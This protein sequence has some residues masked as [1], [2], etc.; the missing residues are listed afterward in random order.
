MSAKS[1]P[2]IIYDL[3]IIGGGINGVGI[4]ADAAGRGLSV[5]LCEQHDLGSATSWT[6]SKLIHGGLRY[7]EHYEFKLVKEALS[8]RE[9]LLNKAPHLI[10]PQ[11]FILPHSR[12]L[13]P[14]WMI[15]AG[16]FLYDHLAKRSLLPASRSVNL[17][18]TLSDATLQ[19]QFNK[20]FIYSDC[21]VDDS[22]LVIT[23]ALAA[24]QNGA[25]ILPRWH[26]N[27]AFQL[28][29]KN[30]WQIELTKVGGPGKRIILAKALVN[31]TGPWAQSFIENK[32]AK[33]SPRI[34]R[35]VKGSHI[36][37][38]NSSNLKYAFI[39]QNED[40]RVVF[41]IPY[42]QHYLLVG[43]TDV[44]HLGSLEEVKASPEEIEYLLAVYNQYFTQPIFGS[45]IISSFAGVRPL[46]DDESDEASAVTRDY[47][48]EI[49]R[50][51]PS[52]LSIFGG[53]LTTYRRLAESALSLLKNDFPTM[54]PEWTKH[55]PL[56]GGDFRFS[57]LDQLQNQ[58]QLKRPWMDNALCSRLIHGYGTQALDIFSNC[59]NREQAGIDFGGNL[60][61][62]EVDYLIQHEWA[63]CAKDIIWRRTKLGYELSQQQIENLE[64]YVA[65][66]ITVAAN[67]A[68]YEANN[69]TPIPKGK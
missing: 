50:T 6:S 30:V 68:Q 38:R 24:A 53:K 39:L 40:N 20:G 63:H 55:K 25:T 9:I 17:H 19:Y 5:V 37:V 4:A 21:T 11:Q 1:E 59:S 14:A 44:A 13:R 66:R 23:N 15:R 69:V 26:C 64:K 10:Q 45:D 48:L 61:Q 46:C 27:G 47:T 57:E 58:L 49:D 12:Q 52:L 42:L 35:L 36:V 3:C 43:T 31:A 34:I 16:L 67:S 18:K 60:F 22:R 2:T 41:V 56:P 33:P 32:L 65:D 62:L 54:G 51:G 8:E 28:S 29:D 7:L